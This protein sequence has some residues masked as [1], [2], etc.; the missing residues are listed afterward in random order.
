MK[1]K[2]KISLAKQLLP[3][4]PEFAIKGPMMIMQPME[5]ILRGVYFEN[6]AYDKSIYLWVFVMPLFVPNQ[7]IY[8]NF[9]YRISRPNNELWQPDSDHFLNDLKQVLTEQLPFLYNVKSLD[10]FIK[11]VR[12]QNNLQ[13]LNAQEA[14][15]YSLVLNGNTVEAVSAL[16]TLIPLFDTES[17]WQVT[18]QERACT[19]K[20]TLEES[21]SDAI[22]LLHGWEAETIKNL[23]LEK[24]TNV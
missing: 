21:P 14:I 9:G 19:L 10:D 16:S 1:I 20:T 3:I 4:M 12:A 8:F 22:K 23:N 18:M 7:H 24:L 15:A 17:P 11:T 5:H 2:E 13:D 6:S